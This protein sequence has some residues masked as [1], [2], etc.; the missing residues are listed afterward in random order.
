METEW[1]ATG[2]RS[3]CSSSAARHEVLHADGA[4]IGM[5]AKDFSRSLLCSHWH[6][7]DGALGPSGSRPTR[8][9]GW[10]FSERRARLA[11][12]DPKRVDSV[13][14]RVDSVQIQAGNRLVEM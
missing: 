1:R 13:Q 6:V 9:A 2:F 5:L 12:V 7:R 11:T 14:K 4:V 10:S 8:R 3:R